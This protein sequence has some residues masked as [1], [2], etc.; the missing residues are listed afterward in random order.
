MSGLCRRP[1]SPSSR[2]FVPD[3]QTGIS[4]TE[5]AAILYPA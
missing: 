3:L 4:I 5:R 2:S 1:L